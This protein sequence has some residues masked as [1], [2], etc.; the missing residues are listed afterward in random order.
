MR[1]TPGDSDLS[2]DGIVDEAFSDGAIESDFSETDIEIDALHESCQSHGTAR[3]AQND[4]EGLK[5]EY[6][7]PFP[8]C[9][10]PTDY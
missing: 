9:L 7:S 10:H 2:D 4:G 8:S 6:V 1:D 3:G 5:R